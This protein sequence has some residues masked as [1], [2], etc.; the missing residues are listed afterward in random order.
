MKLVEEGIIDLDTPLESYLP[1]K[2]WQYRPRAK[3]H[4]DFSE[5]KKDSAYSRITARMCLAHT[6]GFPNWRWYEEDKKLKLKAKPG[7]R[8]LY[9]GEGF[10][11]LQVVLEKILDKN[12]EEI[13]QEKIFKPLGMDRSA[14]EWKPDFETNFAWGHTTAG[15]VYTKDT[16]NE[17]RSASTMET[18]AADYTEFLE[19]VLQERLISKSSWAEL[20]R[21]QIRIRSV[22]TFGPLSQKDTSLY[23]DIELSYG[24]G[25][26]LLKTPYG[27]GAFKEGHGDGFQ[28]YSV[29]FPEVGKGMMIMTNSDNGEGIFKELLEVAIGDTY[30]PWK[31]ENYIP[32]NHK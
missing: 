11:Y 32:Y 18:T 14:Y 2:I 17:P 30:T 8:Y 7:S 19:A 22:R 21:P 28:H 4:D 31:W 26:G 16:D 6:S 12:L 15:K 10:V 24:L 27:T 25:W 1:R 9:S 23:D 3:W 29:L 20:F 13:A 5:L